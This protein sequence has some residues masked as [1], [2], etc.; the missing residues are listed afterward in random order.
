MEK[1]HFLV[2][3]TLPDEYVEVY[4]F[5]FIK[6]SLDGFVFP[7]FPFFLVTQAEKIVEGIVLLK[8]SSSNKESFLHKLY[9]AL[10]L[11]LPLFRMM[12]FVSCPH[13]MKYA[14]LIRPKK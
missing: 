9:T 8:D 1:A 12:S 2:L 10:S 11:C 3:N 14:S 5:G 7:C 4:F 6:D 13:S